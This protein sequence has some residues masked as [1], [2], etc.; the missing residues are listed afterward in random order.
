MGIG[1]ITGSC[2]MKRKKCLQVFHKIEIA[3]SPT[4]GSVFYLFVW[5]Y[6]LDLIWSPFCHIT[7]RV[8]SNSNFQIN[9]T[10]KKGS[11]NV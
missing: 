3:P 10:V 2:D 5:F 8:L 11:V 4:Q 9:V 6:N 7:W 1:S